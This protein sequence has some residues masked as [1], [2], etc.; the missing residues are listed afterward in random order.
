ML[1][2]A[3]LVLIS[4]VVRVACATLYLNC[5]GAQSEYSFQ[6][7]ECVDVSAYVA[8]ATGASVSMVRPTC[9]F[10]AETGAITGYSI[11]DCV[12]DLYNYQSPFRVPHPTYLSTRVAGNP[13]S[14][15]KPAKYTAW[16]MVDN[17]EV[18]SNQT[19]YMSINCMGAS[20]TT[21]AIPSGLHP[22]VP[23]QAP[24]SAT[25]AA[26]GTASLAPP[27]TSVD[28]SSSSSSSVVIIVG[29]VISSMALLCVVCFCVVNRFF[30]TLDA[31]VAAHEL[32]ELT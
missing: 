14:C 1:N 2:L 4:L 9:E 6:D 10:N 3:F 8:S 18:Y 31:K 26:S 17:R 24:S 15:T 12:T 27:T 19:T 29:I 25:T 22:F 13:L 28:S 11:Q 21:I 23:S 30:N 7:G 32:V 20:P 5:L 16:K